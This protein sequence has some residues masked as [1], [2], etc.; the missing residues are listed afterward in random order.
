[1]AFDRLRPEQ[2]N[3][4]ATKSAGCKTRRKGVGVAMLSIFFVALLLAAC[5]TEDEQL[6]FIPEPVPSP[7]TMSWSTADIGG[8][9]LGRADFGEEQV[10]V[11]GLGDISEQ[12]DYFHLTYTEAAGDVGIV[13]RLVEHSSAAGGYPKAGITMRAN[14]EPGAP[15]VTIYAM[16]NDQFTGL[17]L[18]ARDRAGSSTQFI[19]SRGGESAPLWLRLLRE[20]AAVVADVSKDGVNWQRVGAV[21]GVQL[22]K[23]VLLGLAAASGNDRLPLEATYQSVEIVNGEGQPSEPPQPTPSPTPGPSP[24][25]TPPPAS[26]GPSPDPNPGPKTQAVYQIDSSTSFLNPERGF[27]SEVN[28]MAGVGFDD[29]RSRG[30]TLVR[31]YV[32]LDDYRTR[33]IPSSFLTDLDSGLSRARAAGVKVVLRFSYNFGNAPDAPLDWVL[34]HIDQ[35]GPVLNANSDVISVLQAGF[36]GG[37]GEWHGST[38]NL[39]TAANK[40]AIGEALLRALDAS[41]MIQVRAPFHRRDIVGSPSPDVDFFGTSNQARIG[42]KN[43]CF[44][45]DAS[46]TGTYAG[47]QVRDR[48]ETQEFTRYTVTGGETCTIG[49]PSSRQDCS[50]AMKELADFHWDYLNDGY[51]AAVMNRWR[52]QGCYDEIDRRLGYRLSLENGA[53]T[54]GV[55]PGGTLTL[56]LSMRNDG[57][58]KVYN[59]RPIDIVLRSVNTGEM[60]TVRATSD[61]RTILPLAGETRNLQLSVPVPTN[62][63]HGAY[64]VLLKLPDADTSLANDVRYNIRLANVGTWQESTGLNNLGLTTQ[65]GN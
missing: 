17:V 19:A 42:F 62:L 2:G 22:D 65:I 40:R 36:I 57:F 34:T 37:W 7:A 46:D 5:S 58:G 52:D 50:V 30:Y 39:A 8:T 38:N 21:E 61:A 26:P 49:Y 56:D 54:A 31:A 43:D 1:M 11:E 10:K 44:L 63:L 41:R 60:R 29:A 59:P 55:S 3:Q 28:L 16:D 27:H 6:G 35:L 45:S 12:R 25:P 48:R 14:L 32:R 64:E 51:Y 23:E 20:G 9:N 53:V 24:S 13:A 18:Q 15:N 4:L 47:D 33:N